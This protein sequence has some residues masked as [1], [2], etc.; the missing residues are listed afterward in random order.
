MKKA[1]IILSIAFILIPLVTSA[2][3][4]LVTNVID[5][6]TIELK[7]NVK[8]RL[9][10]VDAP[11]L[12]NHECYSNK[13]KNKLETLILGKRVKLIYDEEKTDSFGR[14][15]AFVY[16]GSKFINKQI[17]SSGNGKYLMIGPNIKNW[18]IF[19]DAEKTARD[20]NRG[21]W[22]KCED[23]SNLPFDCSANIYNCSDFNSQGKA[24]E[25]FNYCLGMITGDVHDLDRDG[26]GLACE[27]L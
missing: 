20:K 4:Y 12:S 26:N 16:R 15:L 14:K 3:T 18:E 23:P 13:S 19:L 24:Q 6:D 5:G 21:L 1:S 9:I 8:V 2:K 11:E 27:S 7:N 25:I 17:L 22:K 10:G